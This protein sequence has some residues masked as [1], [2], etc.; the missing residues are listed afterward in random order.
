[1]RYFFRS[2]IPSLARVLL[3]ESGSRSI[4]E[5]MIPVFRNMYGEIAELDAV[6]CFAGAPRGV[7]GRIYRVADYPTPQARK[8]LF[9]E[10]NTRGYGAIGIICSGEP[11]MTKWKLALAARVRAKVLIVNEN[12]DFFWFDR[13]TWRIILLF[14][15]FRA[16]ITGASAVPALARL[17]FFPLAAAFLLAYA[18]AVHFRRRIRML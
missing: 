2:T 13:R 3:V 16:G 8:L 7:N 11:I 4:L 17:L 18:G 15:R 5:R 10:L 1:L 14:L 6:T 9:A 12:G